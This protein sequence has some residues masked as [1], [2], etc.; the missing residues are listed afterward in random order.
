MIETMRVTM[1]KILNQKEIMRRTKMKKSIEQ[2]RV[3]EV[4]RTFEYE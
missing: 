1:K 3:V 2:T 4:K